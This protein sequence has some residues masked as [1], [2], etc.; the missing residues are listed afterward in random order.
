MENFEN[1]NSN[2]KFKYEIIENA[3]VRVAKACN[4]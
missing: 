4:P 2:T 1:K 3:L